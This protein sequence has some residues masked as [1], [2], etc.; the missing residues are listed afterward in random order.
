MKKTMDLTPS[1]YKRLSMNYLANE[2]VPYQCIQGTSKFILYID[3]DVRRDIVHYFLGVVI[4][5]SYYDFVFGLKMTALAKKCC[6]RFITNKVVCRLG[7]SLSYLLVYLNKAW[8]VRD[9][10]PVGTRFFARP[11]R[12]WGPPSLL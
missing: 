6:W 7:F 3:L 10:I 4:Y 2:H 1:S 12:L 9:R 8:T 11:D 5:I